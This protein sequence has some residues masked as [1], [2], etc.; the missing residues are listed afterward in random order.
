MLTRTLHVL[1]LIFLL[2]LIRKKT[3]NNQARDLYDGGIA[4]L[5]RELDLPVVQLLHCMSLTLSVAYQAC[6]RRRRSTDT[7]QPQ[8]HAGVLR[9]RHLG[10][11]APHAACLRLDPHAACLTSLIT[12][13][14]ASLAAATHLQLCATKGC[15]DTN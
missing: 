15:Q 2:I 13:P 8:P 10:V 3:S 7:A 12:K 9:L 1:I 14:H 5:S 4:L 6:G 11:L